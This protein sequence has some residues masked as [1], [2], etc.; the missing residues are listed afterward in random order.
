M[1]KW[2]TQS[3][4]DKVYSNE[5]RN[6]VKSMFTLVHYVA[7]IQLAYSQHIIWKLCSD[8]MFNCKINDLPD[9]LL[10]CAQTLLVRGV[11]RC[12]ILGRPVVGKKQNAPFYFSPY[13][14]L[15]K[16]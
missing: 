7:K 13:Y 15:P 8:F 6:R 11:G 9:S 16:G 3:L 10:R 4:H 12:K 5:R 14:F 1:T 2:S